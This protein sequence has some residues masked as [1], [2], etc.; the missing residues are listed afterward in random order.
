MTSKVNLVLSMAIGGLAIHGVIVACGSVKPQMVDAQA[1]DSAAQGDMS[2]PPGTIVAFAGTTVPTGWALCDG[3]PVSR[4]MYAGLFTAIGISFGGGD[5]INT[6]N[7]PDLR[8]RFL[9]GVDGTAGRD[10]DEL[11]RTEMGPGGNTGNRV[12]SI[13]SDQLVKHTHTLNQGNGARDQVINSWIIGNNGAFDP[14]G[15]AGA[16]MGGDTASTGGSET[17]PTNA[18][19]NWIIKQ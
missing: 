18:Y 17:R 12:G 3:S 14:S 16:S 2:V 4:T 8:G 5:G 10:P 1:S 7:L 19:V 9:R 15:D 6:F 11:S 13:Q